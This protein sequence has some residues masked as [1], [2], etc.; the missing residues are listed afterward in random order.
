[1]STKIFFYELR[2]GHRNI[3]VKSDP[4]I[5]NWHTD[6]FCGEYNIYVILWS[7]ENPTEVLC[8]DGSIFQPEPF[9]IMKI[10]NNKVKHRIPKSKFE[11]RNT[12]IIRCMKGALK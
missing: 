1:M 8:P 6:V 4:T 3:G 10:D 7:N 9:E 2:D 5:T 12:F 11:N